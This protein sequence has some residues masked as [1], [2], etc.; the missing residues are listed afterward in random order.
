MTKKE[1]IIDNDI[2]IKYTPYIVM[3][4]GYYFGC[5]GTIRECNYNIIENKKELYINKD[6][7]II[8]LKEYKYNE[9]IK[10]VNNEN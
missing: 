2:N 4:N 9:T 8:N 5:F 7:T 3:W 10:D 1:L 6:Y